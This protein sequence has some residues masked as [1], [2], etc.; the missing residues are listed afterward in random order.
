MVLSGGHNL[1]QI[2]GGQQ[3]VDETFALWGWVGE[4]EVE[5]INRSG[6]DQRLQRG[7]SWSG[8]LWS[9]FCH[10]KKFGVFPAGEGRFSWVS[11][12][13][14]S[15]I[16]VV[17]L[18][19]KQ[20][21]RLASQKPVPWNRW[22]S[23]TVRFDAFL[24]LQSQRGAW[25]CGNILTHPLGHCMGAKRQGD[26]GSLDMASVSGKEG[27]MENAWNL[28]KAWKR[29]WSACSLAGKFLYCKFF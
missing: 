17:L 25:M 21:Q 1:Q 20:T 8:R 4:G 7:G 11:T 12:Q 14:S 5:E 28:W 24:V 19:Q 10:G 16:L 3:W 2:L 13:A 15:I 9:L 29:G 27:Q 18:W 26:P 22:L 23:L 6:E